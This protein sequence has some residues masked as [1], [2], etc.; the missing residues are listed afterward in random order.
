LAI[1]NSEVSIS[2]M[3]HNLIPVTLG[4]IASG[5]ILMGISYSWISGIRTVSKKKVF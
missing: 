1:N 5:T 2:G 4:N 3:I